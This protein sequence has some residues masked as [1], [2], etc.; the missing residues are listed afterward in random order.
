MA[1]KT[2]TIALIVAAG[3][4]S[5]FGGKI[6]KQ[7]LNFCG[8][9]LWRWSYDTLSQHPQIDEVVLVIHPKHKKLYPSTIP[10]II[11]G[12]TRQESV[13]KGLEAIK[14]HTPSTVLIHDAARPLVTNQLI[15]SLLK[16][17]KKYD[18]MI[19]AN[20]VTDTL[21]NVLQDTVNK[22]VSR[23]TLYTVATPQAFYFTPIFKAHQQ[24]KN[25]PVTDDA[26]VAEL[27]G[28]TVG[29]TPYDITLTKVTT[30]KDLKMLEALYTQG[31]DTITAQG[32]DIH[33]LV[34]GNAVILGGIK[35][36]HTHKLDGHSDADVVL[37]AL[38]D[39]LLGS[40]SAGDIGVHFPPSNKK[41][42]GAASSLFVKHAVKLI[43]AAQ[44]EIVHVD[45]T[46]LAEAPKISAYRQKIINTI[47]KLLE[48]DPKRVG[49][50]ATTMEG[51]GAIG[52]KEGIAAFAMATVKLPKVKNGIR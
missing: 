21:K 45:L 4:G 20:Q 11:G 48:I 34:K 29:I 41:W 36:P 1:K 17:L 51:L 47:A 8:K 35:I 19:P 15:D 10:T 6:A 44:G 31:H 24:A 16:G 33:R 5:R 7:F 14:K 40:I 32:F 28:L 49:L 18:G 27:A 3:T 26:A 22:N 52:N 37:H 25:H 23:E 43:K 2:K 42:K 50:K 38:T 46:L 30:Q 39:A 13:L 12:K 9:P